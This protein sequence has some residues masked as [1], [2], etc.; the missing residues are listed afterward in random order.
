VLKCELLAVVALALW[1]PAPAHAQVQ[2][3]AESTRE[4]P[5]AK[6][7]RQFA[8]EFKKYPSLRVGSKLRLDLHFKSQAEW[9]DFPDDATGSSSDIFDLHRARIGLDGRFSKYVEYQVEREMRDTKRPWRDAFVNVRPLKALEVQLGRFKIPFSLDQ[10]TGS[11]NVD[12]AY[13]SLAGTYLA[14]GRDAGVMAHGAMLKKRL[15][16]EAGIFHEGGDNARV[17]ED[18]GRVNQRTIAGRI[19]SRPWNSTRLPLLHNLEVGVA[20]TAGQVPEGLNS[21]RAETIPGERLFDR[22]YVNGLRR[23]L[24]AELQWQPGPVSVQGEVIRVSEERR[25]QGIDNEN[26]PDAVQ[27]GWYLSGTWL[28]TGEEKKNNINPSRP[29]LQGGFGALEIGA[30]VEAL[31]FGGGHRNEPAL[32]GPRA[33]R[34]LDR[35]DA[36]WT[37]GM[38]WYLNQ[39]VRVQA[40]VIREETGSVLQPRGSAWSRTLRLQFQM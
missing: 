13:R 36:A 6:A 7:D 28:I 10:M 11:M 32:P 3:D 22:V 37:L 16:Y 27:R 21:L 2:Q 18:V 30:R 29:F 12:F 20:F 35:K 17:T 8:F 34:I 24:G 4:R 19:V 1:L 15:K 14:P 26:L 40:N 39:F 38:N 25:G 33:N 9:H 31:A 23:R 5:E